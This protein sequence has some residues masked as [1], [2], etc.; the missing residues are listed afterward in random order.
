MQT[1]LCVAVRQQCCISKHCW[2]HDAIPDSYQHHTQQHQA[3]G[4]VGGALLHQRNINL[5]A[6]A[7]HTNRN[8]GMMY[9]CYMCGT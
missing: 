9:R 3:V 4:G 1:Y 5:S 8:V 6:T 7:A 2:L